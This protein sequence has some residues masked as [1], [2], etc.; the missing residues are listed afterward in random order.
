[1]R[2]ALFIF[3]TVASLAAKEPFPELP[4]GAIEKTKA[5]EIL[6]EQ[7]RIIEPELFTPAGVKY[8]GRPI[9][10]DSAPVTIGK[11]LVV[12]TSAGTVATVSNIPRGDMELVREFRKPPSNITVE[13]VLTAIDASK[14]TITIKAYGVRPNNK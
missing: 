2:T 12:R 1:M 9:R 14:R 10:F 7:W 6:A 5:W 4:D 3:L 13:G 8:L 11:P